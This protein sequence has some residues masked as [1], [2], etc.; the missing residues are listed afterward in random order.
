MSVECQSEPCDYNQLRD[1]IFFI[2]QRTV[3]NI[4][5]LYHMVERASQ[6]HI[7]LTGSNALN[8]HFKLQVVLSTTQRNLP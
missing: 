8:K 3:I 2:T 6:P 1:V 7:N 4:Q 5:N